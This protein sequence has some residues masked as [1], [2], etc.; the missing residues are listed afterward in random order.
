MNNEIKYNVKTFVNSS[1]KSKEEI[2]KLFN[3]KLIKLIILSETNNKPD[4]CQ[5]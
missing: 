4:N 3:K 5:A 1:D 2:I